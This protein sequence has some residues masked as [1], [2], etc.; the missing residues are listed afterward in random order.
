MPL[1]LQMAEE[2]RDGLDDLA[3]EVRS[4]LQAGV[5]DRLGFFGVRFEGWGW[6]KISGFGLCSV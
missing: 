6:L 4:T 1:E 2:E 3:D 5:V